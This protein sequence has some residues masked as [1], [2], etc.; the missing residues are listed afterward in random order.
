MTNAE[1]YLWREIRRDRFGVRFYRQRVFGNYI[2]DFYCPKAKLIIEIDGSQHFKAAHRA[3][4]Q[5]R[6]R[7]LLSEGLA[8]IRFDNLQVLTQME[9]VLEVM[10][11]VIR[12]R[13]SSV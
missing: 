5:N 3:R 12:E 10:Y 11:G 13:V 6:D 7:Y 4:D 9:S 2:V 8:V 1:H